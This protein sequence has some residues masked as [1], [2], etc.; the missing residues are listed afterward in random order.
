MIKILTD[1]KLAESI[2][3]C[4]THNP[5]RTETRYEWVNNILRPVFNEFQVHK[6][7]NDVKYFLHNMKNSLQKR[8]IDVSLDEKQLEYYKTFLN[9]CVENYYS[10][11]KSKFYHR[12]KVLSFTTPYNTDI[13]NMSPNIVGEVDLIIK[14]SFGIT[15]V[16]HCYHINRTYMG[17]ANQIA[18]TRLQIAGRFMKLI[19]GVEPNLLAIIVFNKKMAY[20]KYFKYLDQPYEKYVTLLKEDLLP[21][22]RRYSVLC[23]NCKEKLCS[24]WEDNGKVII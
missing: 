1:Q 4:P 22:K 3:G 8:I 20:K 23:S 16:N 15:L 7:R 14:T 9:R 2:I 12:Y 24:P 19:S 10:L 6:S 21:I 17:Y 5:I 13:I 18:A 11:F